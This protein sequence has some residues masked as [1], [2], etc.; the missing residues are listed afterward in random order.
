MQKL[1]ID[2]CS[3]VYGDGLPRDKSLGNLFKTHGG[4][5]VTD[6]SR[7]GKS[8]LAIALDTYQ[9][10][11]DH[12]VIILGFTY[13]SR[14]YIKYNN[15]N[16]DFYQREKEGSFGLNDAALDDAHVHVYKYFYTIFGHPYCDDLS[17]MVIDGVISFLKA[18]GKKVIAFS[19]QTRNVI[20]PMFY[21]YIPPG[22]RLSDGH[23]N[24][25]GMIELYHYLQN[26][27]GQ[28]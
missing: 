5:D 27:N 26:I 22:K 20:S 7:S 23:L 19:W 12:D 2:G 3:L 13:S 28:K 25:Q 18:Q 10:Y 14:F 15:Q 9:N 16:L 6:L 24:E 1:Y 17:D 21:P 4:Y 8:N 11:K